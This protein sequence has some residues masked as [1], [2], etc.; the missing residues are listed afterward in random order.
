MVSRP[1]VCRILTAPSPPPAPRGPGVRPPGGRLLRYAG[2]GV[3]ATGVHVAVLGLL[4]ELAGVAPGWGSAAGAVVGAQV[5]FVGNRR[6]TFGH[7]GPVGPAWARFQLTALAG[8]ALGA[9][10]VAVTTDLG[11][12]WL[13]AQALAT[14]TVLLVTFAVN[15]RWSFAR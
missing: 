7:H 12:H 8:G 2:V 6:F 15:R 13:P 14:V 1:G 3:A 10:I 4:V 11:L 5:A 9:A